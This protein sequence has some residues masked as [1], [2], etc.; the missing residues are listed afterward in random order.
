MTS[1]TSVHPFRSVLLLAA[2]AACVDQPVVPRIAADYEAPSAAGAAGGRLPRD[3]PAVRIDLPPSPRPWDGDPAALAQAVFAG[4]GY[5]IVGFKEPGSARALATGRRGAVTAGTV[6]AGLELLERNGAEVIELLDAI[7]AAH[8][9]MDP[10][11]AARLAAHPLV[12]FVEPRQ[13]GRLQAQTTPWGITMAAAPAFWSATGVTGAGAKVQIIDSGYQPGHPDLPVV[14]AANCAGAYGGCDD[15][16]FSHGTH[17]MGIVLARDN[18]EGVVGMAPGIAA[19]DVFMYGACLISGECPTTAVTAGI[20]A[21][22][23][24]AHVIN[25]S[26][27]QHY[28][29]AQST[30]VAQAWSSGI[31]L[32]AAAGNNLSDSI[33]YPAGYANVI[34]V[35][36]VMSGKN[37]AGPGTGCDGYSNYG[38]HV[39]LSAPFQANSTFG[40]G[41]QVQ[42][43]TS[44]ATPHVTGAA[45]LL[46]ARNPGMTNQQ[47]VNLLFANAE[48][49]GAVGRDDYYGHGIVRAIAA[50]RANVTGA[51]VINSA[52]TYTWQANATGG[53]GGNTYRWEHRLQGGAWSVV[54]TGSTYSRS[55]AMSNGSFELRVTV[56]SAGLAG[57]D[58]HLVNVGLPPVAVTITGPASL[59]NGQSGTWQANAGGGTGAYTYQWQFRGEDATTWINATGTGATYTRGSGPRSFYLRVIVTSGGATGSDEH[60]V[61]VDPGDFCG[62]LCRA[63][64]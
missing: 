41:Y 42:C 21:A 57:T 28:D 25:L 38:P 14:P 11:A 59:E 54:G 1:P 43:G 32:V 37:F 58:T 24:R 17:V 55:V 51:A 44:M 19:A 5:A 49:R 12:D 39:D 33:V 35:S 15:T 31:V 34:G 36:G 62:P 8:V 50:P 23:G 20:N 13:S 29:V 3:V 52:G 56:T 53:V 60:F 26:L 2:L 22:I 30:A 48:D 7:G 40:T 10:E 27:H 47:I 18:T 64:P 61:Y 9:R 45:A 16:F 46:K 6:R 63:T 4:S